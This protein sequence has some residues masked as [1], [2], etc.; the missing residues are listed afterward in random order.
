MQVM[1]VATTC[2]WLLGEEVPM[3]LFL[4]VLFLAAHPLCVSPL[5]EDQVGNYDWR[6][7][8]I[9]SVSYIS[10]DQSAR[11]VRGVVAAS[12]KGV[13]AVLDPHDGSLVWRQQFEHG[14]N[15]GIHAVLRS[16][17][18][19][20]LTLSR[21]GQLL[22]SWDISSGQL[23]YEV[24]TSLPASSQAPAPP[25]TQTWRPGGVMATLAGKKG[26]VVVIASGSSVAGYAA[27]SGELKWNFPEKAENV[28]CALYGGKDS[29][30]VLT[31][32]PPP[33]SQ[34]HVTRLN[35]SNGAQLSTHQLAPAPWLHT[36]TVSCILSGERV[37]CVEWSQLELYSAVVEDTPSF[38]H[39]SLR[40]IL[41]EGV[42]VSLLPSPAADKVWLRS[43]HTHKLLVLKGWDI[44][45][46]RELVGVVMLGRCDASSSADGE[47]WEVSVEAVQS[48]LSLTYRRE[49]E[50]K[51]SG[52]EGGAYA[53]GFEERGKPV[54]ATVQLYTKTDQSL[55]S[56]VVMVMEDDSIVML[57]SGGEGWVREDGLG[58]IS[59]VQFMDMPADQPAIVESFLEKTRGEVNP[60]KLA[61]LRWQLQ[62]QLFKEFL[63][64]LQRGN[65]ASLL[66]RTDSKE[67][68]RDQFN[69]R[70][71]ILAVTAKRKV[72]G[73]DTNDGGVVWQQ[74]FPWLL[75]VAGGPPILYVLRSTSHPL[76]PPLAVLIGRSKHAACPHFCLVAFNPLTGSPSNGR[77]TLC[78]PA[79]LQTLLLGKEDSNHSKILLMLT[80][81]MEVISY[82]ESQEVTSILTE[83]EE[84]LFFFVADKEEG[85]IDG[86]YVNN[87]GSPSSGVTSF[88]TSQLWH[89]AFPNTT[90][91]LLHLIPK[92]KNEYVS[93]VGRS[94]V[95][96]SIQYKYLNP[97]LLT[98]V[99]ESTDTLRP[100]VSI[101]LVDVVTGGVVFH[102]SHKAATAPV[103]LV[104]SENWIVYQFYNSKQRRH[105][106][107][108]LELYERDSNQT[109][110]VWSSIT[111]PPPPL[112]L[113][114][115]FAIPTSFVTI[116]TTQ[117]RRGITAKTILVGLQSGHIAAVP[118][119]ILDPRREVEVT[120][121]MKE[122]GLPPYVPQLLFKPQLFINYNHTVGT[123][124][125]IYS[126]ASGLESTSLVLACG[127]DLYFTRVLPSKQFDLL[128]VDFDYTLILGVVVAM[129]VATIVLSKLSAG[130]TLKLLWK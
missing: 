130:K 5:S 104:H 19:S 88:H 27:R 58:T 13:L 53:M 99:T 34:L 15:G 100:A 84:Q 119:N 67:L 26:G 81:D 51:E 69:T 123:L 105:E 103:H 126:T 41:P 33:T 57:E 20:L 59:T 66:L 45:V 12:E 114:Q 68:V 54:Q 124:T 98:I 94:R 30:Q 117:T 77:P 120:E 9:G 56:H 96:R 55:V 91:R 42:P 97:N 101:Y 113:T 78:L 46:E 38:Q 92:P 116:A 7:Q 79:L 39:H 6:R 47:E 107:V 127:L 25:L 65:F 87:E 106:L 50:S 70:K 4:W 102:T 115:A 28:V 86:Y 80:A 40:S 118:K 43:G 95:D 60:I 11:S 21:G 74:Y 36:S 111:P 72:Y 49:G 31:L 71:M 17:Y 61:F 48:K 29:L 23:K 37:W 62:A 10:V 93:A 32:T 44:V 76:H 73:L 75:G 64:N 22:R 110:T 128:A 52:V 108:V 24:S 122:A 2:R 18:G 14:A 112:V 109:R 89:L 90:E 63:G 85:T 16:K 129:V 3:E 125:N 82:P 8:Y 83:L 1:G 121:E 35:S